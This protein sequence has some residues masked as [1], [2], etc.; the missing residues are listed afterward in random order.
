MSWKRISSL[1]GWIILVVIVVLVGSVTASGKVIY[2]DTDATGTDDGSSWA[3]A[4]NNLL[5]ALGAAQSGD[6][7]RVA[8]G[9]YTPEGPPPDIRRPSNPNPAD[10]ATSVSRTAD[11]SWTPGSDAISHDVYFGTSSPGMFQGNQ[12]GTSFDP[13]TMVSYTTYYWR[14]DELNNGSKTTGIVWS[15]TTVG[16]GPG[17]PPSQPPP[18]DRTATFQL[19]NGVLIKG[20]YAGFGEPDPNSRDIEVYETIL[21]GDIGF[22]G[23]NFDNSFHI[24]TSSYTDSTA[25]LDGFI[26][27]AGNANEL[28]TDSRGGG[29]Y[30]SHSSPTVTNCTFSGNAADS[31]GGGMYNYDNSSPTVT[32]CTFN[33]NSAGWNGGGMANYNSSPT[34][35]NCTFSGNSTERYGGGMFNS[36]SNPTLTNCT[37][38]GNSTWYGGGMFNYDNSSPTVTNCTFNGN[39]VEWTGGGMGN[40]LKSNPT[41]ANCILWGNVAPSGPQ[42]Y[43]YDEISSATVSYSDVQ[44]GW[45]GPGNIDVDPCLVELGYLGLRAY[46]KFDEADGTTAYDSVGSYHGYVHGAQ[47]TSGKIN[48]ALDFDGL[49]NYVEVAGTSNPINMTYMLWVKVDTLNGMWNTLIEFANDTPWFGILRTGQVELYSHVTSTWTFSIG[50]WHHLAVTSDGYESIIYINGQPEPTTGLPN[51]S[52]G[53][54]LGIGYHDGDTHFDGLID[55]V[56]IFKRPLPAEE[57]QQL[58]QNGLV[59]Q[60][61]S[62][63]NRPDYH[64]LPDSPCI[65][66]GDPNYVPEPNETD[67]DGKPRVIA[68]RIDMGA[69]EFNHVPVADAGQDRTV[70]AQAP[71]GAT[72]TLDG[73]GSSDVDSTPGTTD[74]IN[75][76]DWYKLDP[77]DPNAD[78]FL[79]SGR[80]I[81]CNLTIGEHIIVLDVIDKAGE[82]D[83][84]EVT[85]IVQDTTPPVIT[86]PPDVTL[87]CPADTSVEAN[88]SA[89]A[90][91]TCSSVTITHTDQWQPGCG[92]TGTMARTW[93]AVDESGNSS[94]CVHIITVVDTPPDFELSVS[95]T[96]LWPPDHKMVEITPSW[97]VSDKCDAAPQVSLVGI[98]ANEGDNTIGDGHTSND[99][100]INADGSIYL[101]SERSG[102]S[103]DRVYTITYQAV[104]DC[105]NTTVRSATVSIPHDFRVLARIADRWLW[106]GTGRIP[107]DLNG[108]G[109]VNLKDIAIFAN[110]WIK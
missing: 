110:N 17:S 54:G 3:N 86:C 40:S 32:N 26:I 96:M 59:G 60:E 6:E 5:L 74:D 95:P 67:L 56:M 47:W 20:G 72:V 78:V 11:L 49:S 73:S 100:Q 27:T 80:I 85:I 83:S 53:T 41:L 71:W 31:F 24:V 65:N 48:G 99:I 7:V 22:V 106:A 28:N 66:T 38:N 76:F 35:K 68:G 46:W 77:C 23:Y 2:V 92:I 52:T 75:D 19:K 30:N 69:Y 45:P 94:T 36:E 101:R 84:N 61:N 108:D 21:S 50:Q 39:S 16:S 44:G 33:G 43:N 55:D 91:D 51:T 37:F 70:E 63:A 10:G 18:L 107:E 14:I 13:G 57:I 58:Y 103:G 98:V 109:V 42:I 64:L 90:S 34:V 79:G 25:V 1:W 97:R 8:Q 9:V 102:T 87:E 62:D 104:D 93:T 81:D 29:M 15:F 82:F 89:T 12:S 4:Y 88:G 105:G